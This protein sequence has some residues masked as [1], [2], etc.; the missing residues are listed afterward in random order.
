MILAQK[1]ADEAERL[2]AL[3]ELQILDMRER[4]QL[5]A[6]GMHDYAMFLLDCDGGIVSWNAASQQMKGYTPQE[7]IGRNFSIFYPAEDLVAGK[8]AMQLES[9][10]AHGRCEDQGWRIR[11]D[12]S[13]FWASVL[14]TP[15][16]TAAGELRGFSKL[17]R[18]ISERRRLEETLRESEE[19]FRL[20][21]G[22]LEE[23]GIFLL[24]REGNV[25]SWNAGARRI[26]GYEANEIIGR[27]FSVFYPP[28]DVAAGK[29][30][31]ELKLATQQGRCE[32]EGWRIRADGTRFWASVLI[33]ALKDS[34]GNLLGFSKLTRDTSERKLLEEQVA[35]SKE[36]L[37]SIL[38]SSLDG[39]QMFQAVR[40]PAA[41]GAIIDFEY[42]L[43]NRAAERLS[44]RNA[45][46]LLGKRLLVEFPGTRPTGLFDRYVDVVTTGRPLDIEQHYDYEGFSNWFHIVAVRLGDGCAITFADITDRKRSEALIKQSA[47]RLGLAT[48]SAKIGVWDW[49]L[50]TQTI[51]WDPLMFELYGVAPTDDSRIPYSTWTSAVLPE[52][53][54]AQEAILQDTVARRGRSER[55]FRIRRGDGAIRVIQATEVAVLDEH[56]RTSS[57][58]GVNQDITES[59]NAEDELRKL[60]ALAEAAN[61]SK[62]E[63]L[64]NMS[65][66]IRTPMT[67]ILG[68]AEM[69]LNKSPEEC[70]EIGCVQIIKRN[71]LH[72]LELINEILDLSKIEALQM[73]VESVAC[74]I[75]E[76]LSDI[77]A[78]MGPRASERGLV[79]GVTFQGPIPRL[80]QTDP[81]RLRQILVNLIGNAIKFTQNGGINL[82]IAD[83]GAGR[84]KI[85]LRVDVIDSGIGMT[86]EQL[87]RLFQPFT[88]GD[89]SI[90]R[91]FGGTGLW[92]TISRRLARLLNGDVSVASKRG[93]GSTF[94]LRIDGGPSAGA[95]MLQD[96]TEATLPVRAPDALRHAI[97]LSGRV[98]LVEDGRDNQRLLWTLLT[99]AGAAV[100]IAENGQVGVQ[101]A[102]THPFDLILM[103]MQMPVMDGYA[104]T[105]ELRRQGITT[106]IIALTA[107]A[108]AEDRSKCMAIGCTAYLTKHVDEDTLL[109]TVNQHLA[110][111]PI[112]A[113][114]NGSNAGVGVS[115]PALVGAGSGRIKSSFADNPRMKKI[116]PEFVDGL[117]AEVSKM[118]DFLGRN[119]LPAL[120]RVVH[121]LLGACGGYGFDP[122]SEPA[123]KAEES[124]KA[125]EAVEL[126]AAE[127]HALIEVISRIDGYRE[128]NMRA[129]T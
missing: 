76:M 5:L 109:Q 39:V 73:T 58:V 16:R 35:T 96:L 14:I 108:M 30:A 69:L 117:A 49:N 74:D 105:I 12:G 107:F 23:Y 98:L 41:G 27:H 47:E 38:D 61:Q 122:V 45:A 95:E 112:A 116:I 51:A 60:K 24:D 29:P 79:F 125:G 111:A 48:Q 56:Q 110:G 115:T 37:S 84:E 100:A 80:I 81:M 119:D 118:T 43:V 7:I 65:H 11:A 113:A 40:D 20:L 6:E 91:K 32:D 114:V 123:R 82:M 83:E 15:L 55:E 50:L 87:A 3:S 127:I 71:A 75:P 86:P 54:A 25:A 2:K 129:A 46:S 90:T 126:V 18:D 85:V 63:F 89:E 106:P 70:G 21:V 128:M 42:R 72:L 33:T 8:P 93:T 31:M 64:A 104:A 103:D 53:L 67:A 120:K 99:D 26:K 1:P 36:L 57:V 102:T 4:F 94:T 44:G 92:L 62:S 19:R 59:R 34:S 17:V 68:F 28:E 13:R 22:G 10:L 97:T 66:E 52:D 78:L 9:A 77:I 121:Q 124:I 101:L 88:Q